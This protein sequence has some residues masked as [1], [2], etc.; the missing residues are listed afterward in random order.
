MM[1]HHGLR[2]LMRLAAEAMEENR[3]RRGAGESAGRPAGTGGDDIVESLEMLYAGG[4]LERESFLEMRDEVRTGE[5]TQTDMEEIRHLVQEIGKPGSSQVTAEIAVGLKRV[6][7]H[8][9]RLLQARTES[10]TTATRLQQQAEG[11]LAEAAKKEREARR[12]VLEDEGRARMLLEQRESIL[13]QEGRLRERMGQL[14]QD[15]DRMED[16]HRQLALR[17]QEMEADLAR[18]RMG[19]IE[20]EIRGMDGGG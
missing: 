1:G 3:R 6:R 11:S 2:L 9:K 5:L 13:A 8:M 17:E 15:I 10:E 4:R 14:R 20:R 12:L 18:A 7:R 19:N 16:L